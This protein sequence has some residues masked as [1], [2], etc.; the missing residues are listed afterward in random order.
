MNISC[1]YLDRLAQ[2]YQFSSKNKGKNS[3]SIAL[4]FCTISPR[5]YIFIRK[6][7]Y[8]NKAWNISYRTAVTDF[9][10]RPKNEKKPAFMFLFTSIK[11][12][13]QR[14]PIY[15]CRFFVIFQANFKIRHG[16]SIANVPIFLFIYNFPDKNPSLQ[17]NRAKTWRYT[18]AAFF[19]IFTVKLVRLGQSAQAKTLNVHLSL[20]QPNPKRI[21]CKNL[22][23]L[24]S[25]ING[26][27][28]STSS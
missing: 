11:T 22:P 8:Q 21:F 6:I 2:S 25:K 1:F 10:I 7:V 18:P 13:N 27:L 14:K 28:T 17:R 16:R 15:E 20:G 23:K 26:L 5:K 19:L 12:S 3:R 9:G 24:N 4:S